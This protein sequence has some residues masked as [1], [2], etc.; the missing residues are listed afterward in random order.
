MV[1]DGTWTKHRKKRSRNPNLQ[2]APYAA[3]TEIVQL[4][5][6]GKSSKEVA[7]HLGLS[8]KTAK[9]IVPTS[10]VVWIVTL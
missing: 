5:A 3:S 7:A 9:R 1:L 8:V 6:E 4:L 10:C 2:N